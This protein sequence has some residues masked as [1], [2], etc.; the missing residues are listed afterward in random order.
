[1]TTTWDELIITGMD[2]A[3]C[4]KTL[5]KGV[6][7]L[8][9]VQACEVNFMNGTMR[10]LGNPTPN[11]LQERITALGY[12]IAEA[13]KPHIQEDYNG[14]GGFLRFMLSRRDTAIALAGL[15]GV[16]LA[17]GSALV[18]APAWWVGG[19]ELLIIAAVGLPIMHLGVRQ[20]I[21][22]RN[23]TINLLMSLA[24][25]GALVI[26]EWGEAATVIVLFAI[27]E[28]LEGYSTDR[29]RGALQSL[30]M[31]APQQAL[32]VRLCMDCAEHLGQDGYTGG[33]CPICEPHEQW[34]PVAAVALG[35]TVIVRPADRIPLDGEVLSGAS[36]VDQSPI[37]GESIPVDKAAGDLVFA[38]SVNGN[39][40]LHIRATHTAQ[41]STLSRVI[42]LVAEAQAQKAPSERFVDRFARWY[43][44]LVVV[45]AGLVALVPP[46]VAGAAFDTWF[47][48]A[49]ALLVVACPCALV[50]STPVT[51]VSAMVNAARRGILI[52]GGGYLEALGRIRVFAFDKTGTLTQG[53]PQVVRVMAAD[54]AA[55]SDECAPCNEMLTLAGAVER[56]SEHP[57][58][59]AIVREAQRRGVLTQH[60]QGVTALTGQGIRGEINTQAITVGS[61]G[62]FEQH[63]PHAAALCQNAATY[64]AAGQTVMLVARENEVLGLISVA[65]TPRPAARQALA[66]LHGIHKIML[67]G[68]NPAVAAAIA[69]QVGIDEARAELLPADKA[70]VVQKLAQEFGGVVMVGDGVND[71][72]A[73]AAATVGIA[74]GGAGTAQAMETADVVLM[75]DDLRQLPHAVNIS[76]RAAHVIRQ[77]I[78][79][80]LGIKAAF[81][82]LTLFGFT[83][84]WMAVFADMGMSLLVTFNGMRLLNAKGSQHG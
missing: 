45:L 27:G 83:T 1:M 51:V 38:G 80:S 2:C 60:A 41:D 70:A 43:T 22:T 73:L 50:I 64:E 37:T 78:G 14:L 10:I 4:A 72:P 34:I 76:R 40:V 79:L 59:Q 65:D 35:E 44:P 18:G 5:E 58:G 48:R 71:A 30:L 82:V 56:Q 12:G 9:G 32:V 3:D 25:V 81:V 52:K 42:R 55:A 61:H 46:L 62:F 20:F 7:Q 36:A 23:V 47:Y 49:L 67:T 13:Q 68:D 84:L 75:Q 54:C 39:A 16:G 6:G 63:Y 28:A 24:V 69:A 21:T 8:A 57:L 11:A 74:M 77:N 26:Q 15:L 33:A 19:L 29:A 17:V 66:D 31:L 53:K